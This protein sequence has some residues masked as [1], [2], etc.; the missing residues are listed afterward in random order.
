MG[1]CGLLGA[2]VLNIVSLLSTNMA[3]WILIANVI[4]WTPSYFL[5]QS[6]LQQ[7][8][9]KT[10]ISLWIFVFTTLGS[11]SIALLTVMYHA[12][13]ASLKNPVDSLRYE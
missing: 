11:I 4:A 5:M 6:F 9:Y 3:K 8:P 7:F 13:T 2:P 10:N 1:G 12:V